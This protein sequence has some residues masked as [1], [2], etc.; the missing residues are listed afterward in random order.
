MN[1]VTIQAA[2][3]IGALEYRG[4]AEAVRYHNSE[5]KG[6]KVMNYSSFRAL[7]YQQ[8]CSESAGVIV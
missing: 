5:S 7:E 6:S 1:P 4:M 2:F 3:I 8:P